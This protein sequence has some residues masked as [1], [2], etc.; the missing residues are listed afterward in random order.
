MI[1][2]VN[3]YCTQMCLM[4]YSNIAST[5]NITWVTSSIYLCLLPHN[6]NCIV[7]FV[8]VMFSC[9]KWLG[10]TLFATE[11]AYYCCMKSSVVTF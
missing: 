7:L 5:H 10:I 6:N 4:Q 8:K 3:K 1:R 9:G 2:T 11:A